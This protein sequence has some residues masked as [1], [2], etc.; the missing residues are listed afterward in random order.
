MP[1]TKGMGRRQARLFGEAPPA[2][3]SA[4]FTLVEMMIAVVILVMGLVAVAQGSV[5]MINQ[6]NVSDVRTERIVA[7]QTAIERLRAMPF[8]SVAASNLTV[9]DFTM[10]WT[11]Q[12]TATN[13][14]L[15]QVITSGPGTQAGTSP[16]Q[17][18][19][20]VVDTVQVRIV[21]P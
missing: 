7:R 6:V 9:G 4:G 16:P 10:T 15:L 1:D 13:S 19:A 14:R 12:S 17:V 2:G 18:V 20:T 5:L 3:G 11:V 21:R 8:V